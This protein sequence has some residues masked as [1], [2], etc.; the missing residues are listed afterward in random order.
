MRVLLLTVT[1]VL[2]RRTNQYGAGQRTQELQ[3]PWT[4]VFFPVAMN[5]RAGLRSIHIQLRHEVQ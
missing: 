5:M 1:C 3:L 2:M 4:I